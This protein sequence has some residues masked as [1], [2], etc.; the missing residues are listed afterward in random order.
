MGIFQR[1]EDE[2]PPIFV[3]LFVGFL[4][5]IVAFLAISFVGAYLLPGL[6]Q[7]IRFSLCLIVTLGAAGATIAITLAKLRKGA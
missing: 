7:F 6:P 3:A 5:A 4:T 2:I 1:F